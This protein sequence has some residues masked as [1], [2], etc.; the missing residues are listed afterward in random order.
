MQRLG[1]QFAN[2]T[3]LLAGL[4]M[5]FFLAGTPAVH[6][7]LAEIGRWG[8]VGAFLAGLFFV[9]TFTVAPA[10]LILFSLA[11]VLPVVPLA[12]VAGVGAMLGDYLL[13]RFVRDRLAAEW[14]PIFSKIADSPLGRLFSSPFFAWLVPV[15]GAILIA[16]PLPDEIGVGMLGVAGLESWKMLSL[17]FVLNTVGILLVVL[18]ASL[19]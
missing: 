17:T 8:Y 11:H 5:F 10:I 3:L 19:L 7:F 12:V 15:I 16:S 1:W 6:A 2:T 14:A 9:S 4:A 13:F 18:T